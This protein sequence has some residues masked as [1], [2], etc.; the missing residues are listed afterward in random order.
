MTDQGFNA[1]MMGTFPQ[2]LNWKKLHGVLGEIKYYY[3]YQNMMNEFLLGCRDK[4]KIL[5]K[6]SIFAM[7]VAKFISK[8]NLVSRPCLY[9]SLGNI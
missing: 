9:I 6:L 7:L 4:G 3:C 8:C 5:I 1:Q 2:Q